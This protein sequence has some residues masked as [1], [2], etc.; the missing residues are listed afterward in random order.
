[1]ARPLFQ[2]GSFQFD[3]PNGVPQTLDRTAEYRWEVQDRLLRD[4][5]AQFIGPGNQEITLDGVLFPG[6]SG[7]QSTMETLRELAAQGEPQ[8]LT[9]GLGRIYGKWAIRRIQEGLST[10]APGGGA[11]QIAFNVSLVRYA[12]DSPG[13]AATPLAFNLGTQLA[14][15]AVPTTLSEAFTGDLSAFSTTG[16]ALAPQADAART[17]GFSLGQLAAI[18]K[19]IA[20]QD[21]VGAALNAFGLSSLT[22]AQQSVWTQLGVNAAQLVQQMAI[23]RGAPSMS[24]ALQALRP[25][26]SAMLTT[27]GGSAQGAAALSNIVRDAA[28]ISAMLDVDPRITDAVRQVVTP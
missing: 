15:T 6:F 22:T 5:A 7:Q 27:L 24:V 10:F 2:L 17:A 1:M 9:D 13:Q 19:S 4:P 14:G 8:M 3:L 25:A 26:T 20:S 21:Y 23:G 28:T 12:E 18:T 11:R 16:W